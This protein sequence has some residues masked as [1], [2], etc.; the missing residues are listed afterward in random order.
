MKPSNVSSRGF[1]ASYQELFGPFPA[2]VCDCGYCI[3]AHSGEIRSTR[4][5][6][7]EGLALCQC[8]KW[9]SIPLHA[10]AEKIDAALKQ[11][12]KS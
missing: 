5:K 7:E 1:A 9:V 3:V 2:I 10:I 8:K 6:L 11:E 12:A 4:I